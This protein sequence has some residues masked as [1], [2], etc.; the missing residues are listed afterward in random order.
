M[1]F[2]KILTNANVL[3][4][5]YFKN[6]SNYLSTWTFIPYTVHDMIIPPKRMAFN[7]KETKTV[8]FRGTSQIIIISSCKDWSVLLC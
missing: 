8:K 7:W 5:M 2:V 6:K 4:K 1:Y 3:V